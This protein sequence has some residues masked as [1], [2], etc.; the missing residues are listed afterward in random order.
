M[1]R[2]QRVQLAR[3]R[4]RAELDVIISRCNALLSEWSLG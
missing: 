1:V 3:L 2:R 4:R